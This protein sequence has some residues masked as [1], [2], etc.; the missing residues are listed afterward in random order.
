MSLSLFL[1][2]QTVPR[3]GDQT[4]QRHLPQEHLDAVDDAAVTLYPDATAATRKRQVYTPVSAI[5]SRR[6]A[7]PWARVAA[8]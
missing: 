8:C 7:A 6:A 4:L 3:T 5:M 1:K 2:A